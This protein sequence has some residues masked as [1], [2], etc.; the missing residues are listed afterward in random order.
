MFRT[1]GNEKDERYIVS[2]KGGGEDG[3]DVSLNRWMIAFIKADD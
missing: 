3:Q 2:W 1:T